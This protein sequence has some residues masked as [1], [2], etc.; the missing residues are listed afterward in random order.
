MEMHV[1]ILGKLDYQTQ[2]RIEYP[3][4]N[5]GNVDCQK[6]IKNGLD[7]KPVICS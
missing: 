1:R 2:T 6:Y 5:L 4:M 7:F 3:V